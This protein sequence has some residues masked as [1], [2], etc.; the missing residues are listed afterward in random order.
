MPVECHPVPPVSRTN[1]AL[2]AMDAQDAVNRMLIEEARSAWFRDGG[3][4]RGWADAVATLSSKLWYDDHLFAWALY[5]ELQDVEE[6]IRRR[7]FVR[8]YG[9]RLSMPQRIAQRE[10]CGRARYIK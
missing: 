2:T 6:W 3:R 1:G 10:V 4:V 7:A 9:K 5:E 8:R